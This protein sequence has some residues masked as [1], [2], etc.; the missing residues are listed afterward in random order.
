MKSMIVAG[1]GSLLPTGV[2]NPILNNLG[3]A[4]VAVVYSYPPGSDFRP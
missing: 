4:V 2:G 1:Y 3:K